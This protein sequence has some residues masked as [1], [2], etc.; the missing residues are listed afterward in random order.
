MTGTGIC[1]LL[2]LIA[3]SLSYSAVANI[4]P[5]KWV[6]CH[7]TVVLSYAVW[8]LGQIILHVHIAYINK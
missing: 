2:M 4:Y 7:L 8:K 5:E 3:M 6:C 1:W